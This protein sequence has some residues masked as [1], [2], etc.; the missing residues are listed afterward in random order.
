MIE[1]THKRSKYVKWIKLDPSFHIITDID[2]TIYDF[3]IDG[4]L[5]TK[6]SPELKKA[7]EQERLIM[8]L[9]K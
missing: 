8:V 1:F 4:V 9:S 6:M 3:R 5:Y 7:Y 2:C